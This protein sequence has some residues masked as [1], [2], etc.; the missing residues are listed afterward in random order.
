MKLPS[1]EEMLK[2]SEL[3]PGTPPIKAHFM[4]VEVLDYY[5]DLAKTAGAE[6]L[7]GPLKKAALIYVN[8]KKK[9]LLHYKENELIIHENG[10]VELIKPKNTLNVKYGY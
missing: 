4:E 1:R 9:D 10:Q 7:T 8:D 3:P 2:D 5:D 6:T